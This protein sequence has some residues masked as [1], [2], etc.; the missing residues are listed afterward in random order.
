[1]SP[2]NFDEEVVDDSEEEELT[3]IS[4]ASKILD[5][6]VRGP[7]PPKKSNTSFGKRKYTLY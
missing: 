2:P 6:S 3:M 7:A 5:T 1:M 4:T